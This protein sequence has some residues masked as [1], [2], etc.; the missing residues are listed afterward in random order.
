MSISLP[1]LESWLNNLA[2]SSH[3]TSRR[4]AV[5]LLE[6]KANIGVGNLITSKAIQRDMSGGML[7][8][9]KQEEIHSAA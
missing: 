8:P 5:P 1:P 9:D 7:L 6:S 2:A 3:Q 4:A